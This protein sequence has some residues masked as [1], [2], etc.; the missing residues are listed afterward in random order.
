MAIPESKPAWLVR[1]TN[2]MFV[3]QALM[4]KMFR[5][6][7]V[8]AKRGIGADEEAVVTVLSGAK[9]PETVEVPRPGRLLEAL[10]TKD[11]PTPN[12]KVS[13]ASGLLFLTSQTTVQE[14]L[15]RAMGTVG[16]P[17]RLPS[18]LLLVDETAEKPPAPFASVETTRPREIQ[19]DWA[20]G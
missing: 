11:A 4:L 16:V 10:D 7:L 6:E 18:V 5:A 13:P 8:S 3:V 15:F 19:A 17:E 2:R 20:A 9:L 14:P 12:S 1:N